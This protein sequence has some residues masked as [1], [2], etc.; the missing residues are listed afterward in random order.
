MESLM[1]NDGW[2]AEFRAQLLEAY[3]NKRPLPSCTARSITDP[4]PCECGGAIEKQAR[5]STPG[6]LVLQCTGCFE[7]AKYPEPSSD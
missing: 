5:D 3:K 4:P 6:E 7:V 2:S 1:D